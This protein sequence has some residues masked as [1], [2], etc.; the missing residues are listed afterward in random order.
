MSQRYTWAG[1]DELLHLWPGEGMDSVIIA[2]PPFE[3]ANR[4][5]ALAA[6]I[7]R[8]LSTRG[9]AAAVPDL[10]GTGDSL[11]ATEDAR[12]ADWRDAFAGAARALPGRVHGVAFRAGALIDGE[13]GLASRWLLSPQSG[14]ALVR[15]LER[16]RQL[17]DGLAAGN[18]V[19]DVM[20]DRLSEAE[21]A[22]TGPLRIVRLTSEPQ[23][24]D[25]TID[26]APLWRRAEPDN[27]PGLATLLADDITDWI[28]LQ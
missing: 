11:V 6:T 16:L 1:G 22:T 19:S 3:E 21:P 10:P 9:I 27:D 15:E 13:A 17:G 7:A 24:A 20:L 5:R 4:L 18:A 28:A 12:L 26:A 25:L 14:A 8:T 23:P 2:L